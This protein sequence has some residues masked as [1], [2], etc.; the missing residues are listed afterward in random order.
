M[1]L[2]LLSAAALTI[3]AQSQVLTNSQ[4]E[5]SWEEKAAHWLVATQ[6]K[7]GGWG[8]VSPAKTMHDVE[9]TVITDPATTVF[10][11]MALLEVGGGLDTNPYRANI[12]Y[13]LHYLLIVIE[14]HAVNAKKKALTLRQLETKLGMH[15]DA[16]RVVNFLLIMRDQ[17]TYERDILRL[18]AAIV[19]CSDLLENR[20]A[21]TQANRYLI[22]S[23]RY[24]ETAGI[25]LLGYNNEA[26]SATEAGQPLETLQE[27]GLTAIHG[28]LTL[29][30]D[31][32]AQELEQKGKR[33]GKPGVDA[34]TADPV[35]LS[36]T[37]YSE[38]LENLDYD[39]WLKWRSEFESELISS[40]H[41]DGSWGENQN[42]SSVFC[43]AAALL[44]L[45]GNPINEESTAGK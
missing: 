31:V 17:L 32:L 7:N 4:S 36:Y 14:A 11:A 16:T 25:E 12:L 38:S 43:T 35:F 27:T 29:G 9:A 33:K 21:R 13:A 26:Q 24:I 10:A 45:Y 15:I 3:S 19:V 34:F 30:I 5:I 2:A 22:Q 39:S 42:T 37:F 8:F 18:N 41:D 44:A 6:A 20:E 28:L 40:Q 1:A 23:L